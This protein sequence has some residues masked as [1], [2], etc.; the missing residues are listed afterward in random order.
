MTEADGLAPLAPDERAGFAWVRAPH[1]A[2]VVGALS[3]IDPDAVRFVGGCV[4]DGVLGLTANDID[5]ATPL[6]PETVMAALKAA[7][8]GAAPTGIEHGTVTATHGGRGVEITT[9]RADV[10]TDGRRATVAFTEDWRTDAER[11]DFT[12]NAMYLTP[13]LWLFDPMG[14]RAD[15]AAGRVRF[16][17]RPEDRIREDYLRILRFFRFSARFSGEGYDGPGLA[18]C[19]ALKEGI[20]RLSAERVG[21]EF[22]GLL[23]L[24]DP[25]RAVEVMAETGVLGEIWPAKADAAALG[26]LKSASPDADPALCLAALWGARGGGLEKALRLSKAD[27][28][29][30]AAAVANAE[31]ITP[32]LEADAVRRL[33]YRMG[34][35]G[36]ADA[37]RLAHA[38]GRLADAARADA[39]RIAADRP[40]PVFPLAGADF[41]AAGV[42]AGPEVG[43][44]LKAVE[45][46]W[47][48]E[49]F[50]GEARVRAI[51]A[52]RLARRD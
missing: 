27:E 8:L 38:L 34:A 6:R 30:R 10:E 25:V 46:Q 51:L 7:G 50:P 24:A 41:L 17:G 21:A 16:I 5:I 12:I 11:R 47:I 32:S 33:I 48:D 40:P 28:A 14:G 23:R 36:F 15:L 37:V 4:R 29:R 31:A 42:A 43:R 18:A 9:L 3:Q 45:A 1:V 49:G 20:S 2:R 35:D 39:L 22:S 19:A 26:R 44:L 13:D 52:E